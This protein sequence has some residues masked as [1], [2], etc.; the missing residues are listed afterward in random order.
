MPINHWMPALG[1]RRPSKPVSTL[2][3]EPSNVRRA[4]HGT[5]RP[6]EDDL[7]F[8]AGAQQALMWAL[9]YNSAT[10]STAAVKPSE[11]KKKAG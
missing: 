10:P 1:M 6:S 3:R 9:G 5:P 11:R 8:L 4:L 2:K 7:Q